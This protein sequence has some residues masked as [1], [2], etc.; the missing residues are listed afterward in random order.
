MQMVPGK[1][2]EIMLSIAYPAAVIGAL[3]LI[4]R[5]SRDIE[6]RRVTELLMFF[7]VIWATYKRGW[8]GAVPMALMASLALR[9]TIDHVRDTDVLEA[10][11]LVALIGTGALVL[12][13]LITELRIREQ[14]LA[15]ESD[16]NLELARRNLQ[17]G[18]A[19]VQRGAVALETAFEA[20]QSHPIAAAAAG[21]TRAMGS[22]RANAVARWNIE[23][24][25]RGE[26]ERS[27][28]A[29]KLD[30]IETRGIRLAL[31]FGPFAEQLEAAGVEYAVRVSSGAYELPVDLQ[32]RLYQMTYEIIAMLG[33]QFR[34]DRVAVNVR[35]FHTSKRYVVVT[36]KIWPGNAKVNALP[37][38]IL[39]MH[40]V[41]DLART[42]NGL[43]HDRRCLDHPTVSVLLR[44]Y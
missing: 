37:G 23:A 28:A 18:E 24:D 11:V 44:D 33:K 3:L 10:Q 13:A 20:L 32:R 1:A 39:N 29:L 5:L 9:L 15:R 21:G 30:A 6:V 4:N 38:V 34:P 16:M 22:A 8:L 7:P 26:A 27:I 17:W 2:S 36:V 41:R 35:S 43:V 40:D 42:F 25:A 12:G 31:A 19:H 14:I